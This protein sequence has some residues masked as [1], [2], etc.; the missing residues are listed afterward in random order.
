MKWLLPLLLI[1]IVL[2]GCSRKEF[3]TK[4]IYEA[5][6]SGF[7]LEVI[8]WGR[9]DAGYD[10][11]LLGEYDAVFIP[12]AGTGKRI[13]FQG[14]YP[15][16]T[17]QNSHVLTIKGD[18]STRHYEGV[19]LEDILG[20]VLYVNYETLEDDEWRE[21]I[22]AIYGAASGPATT[23]REGQAKYLEVGEIIFNYRGE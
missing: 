15:D 14:R 6:K 9:V 18:G 20:D 13:E 4:A 10:V 22:F 17:D 1:S 21:S 23:I 16:K 19:F 11:A 2:T 12:T 3:R 8:G 7:R 5:P